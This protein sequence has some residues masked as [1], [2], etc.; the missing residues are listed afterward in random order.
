MKLPSAPV[1][2]GLAIALAVLVAGCFGRQSDSQADTEAAALRSDETIGLNQ[3]DPDASS[4]DDG[5][6]SSQPFTETDGQTAA[7]KDQSS[8]NT[9]QKPS[10]DQAS[11][12][13]SNQRTTNN[14]QRTINGETNISP[15]QSAT[16]IAEQLDAQINL[17]SRPTT[18]SAE[19]GYGLVGN[20]VELLKS[21]SGDDSFI[22]YYVQFE[23]SSAEGWIRGDFVD[24]DAAAA[25]AASP[26]TTEQA[27]ADRRDGLGEALDAVC[28]GPANLSAY[29]DTERYNVYICNAPGGLTYVSNEKGTNNTLV[30]QSVKTTET[31][32]AAENDDYTYYI[33]STALTI[34]EGNSAEP[35]LQEA[36]QSSE[37]YE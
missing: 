34:H 28:G 17:R 32:Y 21:A 37:F 24:T 13:D 4:Q 15:P 18:E 5:A 33:D 29:Y 7:D 36:V 26:L 20:S 16:L 14:D 1:S 3:S 8:K 31:G 6:F 19:K 30:S 2:V 23:D 12:T 11:T 27:A 9:L 22:W 35:F 25:T 10:S